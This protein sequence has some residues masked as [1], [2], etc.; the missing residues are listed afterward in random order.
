MTSSGSRRF[1]EAK[2]HV[3]RQLRGPAPPWPTSPHPEIS[4]VPPQARI[5]TFHSLV[6]DRQYPKLT[7][8][9]LNNT[10][11][12]RF[13]VSK[14]DV[15]YVTETHPRGPVAL[16]RLYHCA[17][18]PA[19]RICLATPSGSHSWG[20]RP[21]FR[22]RCRLFKDNGAD[23]EIDCT[24]S[25][26]DLRSSQ[27]DAIEPATRCMRRRSAARRRHTPMDLLSHASLLGGF[28]SDTV[29]LMEYCET[30]RGRGVRSTTTIP[31]SQRRLRTATG[32]QRRRDQAWN[33][34]DRDLMDGSL[35]IRPA[36][37]AATANRR[38]PMWAVERGFLVK[39]HGI[40]A[41]I[42]SSTGVS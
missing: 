25:A 26:M 21:W 9:V 12:I 28:S 10:R 31:L 30:C 3:R 29:A 14:V 38:R 35:A 27:I 2:R 40:R 13:A 7:S 22:L 5:C 19:Q 32:V 17:I 11:A 1:V 34:G 15:M 23:V 16:R 20:G 36:G 6:A 8:M 24:A 18:M 41:A 4:I 37:S 33:K 39:Q 42:R